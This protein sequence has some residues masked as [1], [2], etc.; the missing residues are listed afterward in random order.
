MSADARP[1]LRLGDIIV[2]HN[3]II[4]PGDRSGGQAEFVGLEHIESNTGR[5]ISSTTIDLSR[6]TGRKPTFKKRQ[7]VYGYLRPYLN[8]VWIAEFDGCSSVDQFAFRV[9][10]ELADTEYVAAFMRSDV[11]LRRSSI[12]TTTGQLP[13]ISIDEILAVPVEV[14]P[15]AEQ[16]RIAGILKEQL[17]AVEHARA[18][19]EAQLEAAK[20]LPAAYLRD[21]FVSPDGQIG[22]RRLI[23]EICQLLPSKSIATAGDTEV[24]AITTACL[25]ESGF[26]ASGIKTAR[27]W[28]GD[29]EACVVSQNEV[30][31][32]RSNTTELVGRVA[33]FPGEPS[34]AVASDLTIRIRTGQEVEPQFLT[35]YLSFLYVTGFRRE[36]AGGASGSMK[37]ITRSQIAALPVPVPERDEQSAIVRSIAAKMTRVRELEEVLQKELKTIDA[38]PASLLRSAFQG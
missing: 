33:L 12:V 21:V 23:G 5:R 11:F 26:D 1:T 22:N 9:R 38:L 29:A 20:A 31:I 10:L 17:A 19:A 25:T 2:R 18:A 7:I 3:E 24:R 37:K 15:L 8:K 36:R 28:T 16:Q 27:M 4:H 14:P 6:L 34:G 35:S 32:A 13:R 30:L